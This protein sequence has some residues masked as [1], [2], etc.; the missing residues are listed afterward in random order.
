MHTPTSSD[1][2]FLNVINSGNDRKRILVLMHDDTIRKTAPEALKKIVKH[3]KEK[4]YRFEA[5]TENT[6]P[7]QFK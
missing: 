2:I 4:G 5:L 1:D 6:K 7:I 3:Y